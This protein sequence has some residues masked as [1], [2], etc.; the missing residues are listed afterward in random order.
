MCLVHYITAKTRAGAGRPPTADRQL[1][2]A[3]RRTCAGLTWADRRIVGRTG[4]FL[5][6]AHAMYLF[7]QKKKKGKEEEARRLDV[8]R[9]AMFK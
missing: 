4:M 2:W 5:N 6:A 8:A 1:A 7:R 9:N 3:D